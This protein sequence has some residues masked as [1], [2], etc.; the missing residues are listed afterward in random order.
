MA[1]S[2]SSA[3]TESLYV[4]TKNCAV[5]DLGLRMR[6]GK[7]LGAQPSAS[8]FDAAPWQGA[9]NRTYFFFTARCQCGLRPEGG[10]AETLPDL[11]LQVAV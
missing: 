3:L 1:V 11:K 8:R 7:V 5:A 4:C 10:V 2:G 6:P 9:A